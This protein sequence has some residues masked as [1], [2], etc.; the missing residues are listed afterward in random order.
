MAGVLFF[1]LTTLLVQKIQTLIKRTFL[2]CVSKCYAK[3]KKVEVLDKSFGVKG[4]VSLKSQPWDIS[5][6]GPN[7]VEVTVPFV[8]QIKFVQVPPTMHE[9]GAFNLDRMCWGIQVFGVKYLPLILTD[10][11]RRR[12]RFRLRWTSQKKH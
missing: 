9:R 8:K 12:D 4:S 7:K 6:I 1:L 2:F 5:E 3:N 11:R 10:R